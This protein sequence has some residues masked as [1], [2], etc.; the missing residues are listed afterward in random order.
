MKALAI[1][2]GGLLRLTSLIRSDNGNYTPGMSL[3][4]RE[5]TPDPSLTTQ[6]LGWGK[7]DGEAVGLVD[8][9]YPDCGP[10][11]HIEIPGC[12]S[13]TGTPVVGSFPELA[14]E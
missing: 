6:I 12:M 10:N 2:D 4:D 8:A 1:T 14:P 9:E 3:A 13:E 7:M 11:G 5:Y